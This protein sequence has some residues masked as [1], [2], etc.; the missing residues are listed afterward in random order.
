MANGPY[1]PQFRTVVLDHR[2][3]DFVDREQRQSPKF[4]NQWRGVEWLLARTPEAGAPRVPASPMSYL[5][6]VI[7][8]NPLAGTRELWVLYSYNQ[9]EVQVHGVEIGPDEE[10]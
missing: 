9:E 10:E 3:Q 1:W 6:Y 8:A 7:P 4:E 5:V 2:A